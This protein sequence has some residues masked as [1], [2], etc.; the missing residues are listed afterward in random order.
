MKI[1]NKL[2]FMFVL[3]SIII[4]ANITPSMSQEYFVD[5]CRDVNG[6]LIEDCT[7]TNINGDI[8]SCT[9]G[10]ILF[11]CCPGGGGPP[12]PVDPGNDG[13][14]ND[15]DGLIDEPDEQDGIN[16]NYRT[17]QRV[18]ISEI[19][20]QLIGFECDP[21]P[22]KININAYQN[23]VSFNLSFYTIW[24]KENQPYK[25]GD[26][27][28][29]DILKVRPNK[30]DHLFLMDRDYYINDIYRNNNLITFRVNFIIP[31][32]PGNLKIVFN[33]NEL[34]ENNRIIIIYNDPVKNINAPPERRITYRRILE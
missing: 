1:K 17:Y 34:F 26:T 15:G 32:S 24:S 14:D 28:K 27:F 22:P 9:D 10:T 31:V 11:P 5:D 20:N 33:Y 6:D 8:V 30:E 2:I 3:F 29:I 4:Q 25:N 23:P 12:D 7:C 13:I 19:K 16:T 18:Q 21:N